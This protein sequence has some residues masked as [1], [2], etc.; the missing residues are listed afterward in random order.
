MIIPLYYTSGNGQ[1]CDGPQIVATEEHVHTQKD[2]DNKD[3]QVPYTS[4]TIRFS[5]TVTDK[6]KPNDEFLNCSKPSA[7]C[8]LYPEEE[9]FLTLVSASK[10][11]IGQAHELTLNIFLYH[12]EDDVA[13]QCMIIQFGALLL[14]VP[15]HNG[16]RKGNTGVR[17]SDIQTGQYIT[18]ATT[19]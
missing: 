2:N 6:M 1:R 17:T 19:M 10:N 18:C 7:E 4:V 16:Y 13:V 14:Y 9:A 5:N 8:G 15:G 12:D 3:I 11:A